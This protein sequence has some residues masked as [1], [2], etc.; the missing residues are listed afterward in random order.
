M[1]KR[2]EPM[3]LLL[4]FAMLFTT[5]S[6]CDERRVYE[7]YY[8]LEDYSWPVSD[9]LSFNVNKK[10]DGQV[11]STLRIK[12]NESYDYYNIYVRY[13]LKDSL[14]NTLDNQLLDLTLFDPKTGKPLGSGFGNSFTQT[15][16]LPLNSLADLGPITIQLVQYMRSSDL[17]GIESVG[18]KLEKE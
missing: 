15:G 8:G 7:E 17:K 11:S 9:T 1:N 6:G 18:I 4:S 10:T 16:T 3:Y 12:Y 2:F 14:N 13:L 5:L